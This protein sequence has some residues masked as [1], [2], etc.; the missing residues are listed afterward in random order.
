[1]EIA[2]ASGPNRLSK[3]MIKALPIKLVEDPRI[4]EADLIVLV[5]TNTVQQLEEWSQRVKSGRKLLVVDHHAVHPE[6]EQL[7]TLSVVDES[8]SS[9]CEIVHR[10]YKE[11]EI[12][13]EADEAKA[14]FLGIAFDTRHFVIATSECLKTVAE[15]VE[16]GV[17]A[18][19]TLPILS[20]PMEH[21]ER[22]ARLKA[23]SR[24]KLLRIDDWLIA[25][26]HVSAFQASACRALI[27]VGA[28]VA[29]VAG[30]KQN[31]L[32]VSF[33]ATREFHEKTGVHMGCDLAK[34]LGEF[35]GGMGGGH[36]VSAGANGVG[37]VEVCLDYCE[38]LI[39]DRLKYPFLGSYS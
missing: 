9:A 39:R 19:E 36:A 30:E 5:D 32:Q 25:L 38:R 34:P 8:A 31:Q 37:D 29:V 2:A 3:A 11:A 26:S 22:V 14:L 12:K 1:M 6:T 21:S 16:S 23:A 10:L 4:E 17:N 7:A 18:E 33:R 15:L 27:T 20:L 24:L 28:H 13:P 35:L